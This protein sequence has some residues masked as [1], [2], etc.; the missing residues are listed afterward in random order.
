ME[1]P[2]VPAI[3]QPKASRPLR[4]P[5]HQPIRQQSTGNNEYNIGSPIAQ[6]SA[7]V[8][9]PKTGMPAQ[10]KSKMF[11][12][13]NDGARPTHLTSHNNGVGLWV[14]QTASRDNLPPIQRNGSVKS[15]P[16][17]NNKPPK[18]LQ[19]NSV[20]LQAEKGVVAL[21][22]KKYQEAVQEADAVQ[23]KLE[24]AIFEGDILRRDKTDLTNRT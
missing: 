21:L 7:R 5:S 19:T 8:A 6:V 10:I 16:Q 12:E 20:D 9:G 13:A 4:A 24:K 3:N 2:P 15:T 22:E 14:H 1:K 23:I 11:Q 18:S 17:N